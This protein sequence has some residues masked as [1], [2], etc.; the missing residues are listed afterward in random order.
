MAR[1]T[2]PPDDD[3]EYYNMAVTPLMP[4][5]RYAVVSSRQ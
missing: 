2:L 3:A 1:D 5:I 4:Y